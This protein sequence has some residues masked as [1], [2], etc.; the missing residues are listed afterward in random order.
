[1]HTKIKTGTL[2]YKIVVFFLKIYAWFFT[3]GVWSIRIKLWKMKKRNFFQNLELWKLRS[4][5]FWLKGM[6]IFRAVY[7]GFIYAYTKPK[8]I[9]MGGNDGDLIYWYRC[10]RCGTMV[11]EDHSD[12]ACMEPWDCPTCVSAV[13]FPFKFFT[14]EELKKDKRVSR[15]VGACAG[16]GMSPSERKNS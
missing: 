14:R 7:T 1:M 6:G 3:E 2:K 16:Q 5:N 9:P 4:E 8:M 10:E 11:Q 15:F 12:I 13:N